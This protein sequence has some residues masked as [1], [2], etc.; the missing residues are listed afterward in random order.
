MCWYLS[1]S[2]TPVLYSILYISC[3]MSRY[4]IQ[5]S[6]LSLSLCSSLKP[7]PLYLSLPSSYPQLLPTPIFLAPTLSSHLPSPS[8]NPLLFTLPPLLPS[9][10]SPLFP[11][12][13]PS[14]SLLFHSSHFPLRSPHHLSCHLKPTADEPSQLDLNSVDENVPTC[15]WLCVNVDLSFVESLII[16]STTILKTHDGSTQ[17]EY[18]S[19]CHLPPFAIG[20][21]LHLHP[22]GDQC[23][24]KTI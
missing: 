15:A 19:P 21:G 4:Y 3:Y 14:F 18:L 23:S 9:S 12:F 16:L 2:F 17:L 13:A 6:L 24:N 20:V 22:L 7:F 8:L 5:G 10:L 1:S 11:F